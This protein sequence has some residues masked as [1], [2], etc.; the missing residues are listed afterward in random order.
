MLSPENYYCVVYLKNILQMSWNSPKML[1]GTPGLQM[2]LPQRSGCD[3]QINGKMNLPL[4]CHLIQIL[5][6]CVNVP[7][8]NCC[9]Q[10]RSLA[11]R[12]QISLSSLL[13]SHQLS[14]HYPSWCRRI[15][16]K[17][18]FNLTAYS[19]HRYGTLS[20]LIKGPQ[21]LTCILE[22]LTLEII[23]WKEVWRMS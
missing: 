9:S 1:Q 13:W 16:F 3:R 17:M 7:N 23:C 18:S 15:W 6:H 5:N 8:Y 10:N 4:F 11:C 22:M 14:L 21:T 12:T 19:Y 20:D 2:D